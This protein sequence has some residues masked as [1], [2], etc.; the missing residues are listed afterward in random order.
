MR[1]L[2]IY[3]GGGFGRETALM[4][5]QINSVRPSWRV[6]GF[7]DDNLSKGMIVDNIPVIGGLV[8]LNS[9][10]QAVSVTIAVADPQ[11]RMKIRDGIRNPKVDYP[12]LVHPS[13]MGGDL[14]RNKIGEGSIVTAGNIFTTNIQIQAFVIVNLA[15][16]IGHDVVIGD[17]SSIMPGCS[18]SGAVN[19]GRATL[20]GTGAR[21]L[22]GV[23]IGESCRVGAGAVVT[24]PVA[25][26]ETV[27]GI[28]AKPLKK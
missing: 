17:F 27:V 20:I 24:K 22:P 28:P 10:A 2:I 26:S 3:G 18:I 8:D 13:V 16:T 9:Y 4:I 19:I 11:T 23:E 12:A 15:C 25:A 6:I 14:A 7:C 5:A 21:I 1:D